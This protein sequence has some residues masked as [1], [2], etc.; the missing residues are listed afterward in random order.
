MSFRALAWAIDQKIRNPHKTV[1][2][3]LAY[4]DSHDPPHGCFPSLWK[5][6]EDCGL[7]RSTVAKSIS[8]L[9]REGFIKRAQ[10]KRKGWLRSS[11]Y[12]F[13]QV[14][15]V[16]D[17]DYSSPPHGLPVVR[18]TDIEPKDITGNEPK[19][20]KTRTQSRSAKNRFDD[21][22]EHKRCIEAKLK[23]QAQEDEVHKELMVGASPEL[24]RSLQ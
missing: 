18:H 19:T 4:R 17:A 11:I 2:L 20:Q 3:L 8:F 12:T 10:R 22:L 24:I 6:A 5:L 23:R 21:A 7:A 1:L 15:A 9:E 16:R 13:P 14:W